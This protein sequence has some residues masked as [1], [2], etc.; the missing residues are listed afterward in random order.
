MESTVER[1]DREMTQKSEAR[2]AGAAC[3][4]GTE[5]R[6]G[7]EPLR[8]AQLVAG[9]LLL[10]ATFAPAVWVLVPIVGAGLLLAGSTGIC[11]M[12]RL[13]ARMPWNRP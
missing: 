7:L 10:V 13:L 12:E 8:Q 5:A 9:A 1:I 3:S 6:R 4:A 11:P 2:Q